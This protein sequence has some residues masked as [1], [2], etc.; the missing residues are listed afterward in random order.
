MSSTYPSSSKSVR[1]REKLCGSMELAALTLAVGQRTRQM[2]SQAV[3]GVF[4]NDARTC[5]CT[6]W[7]SATAA[8][9]CFALASFMACLP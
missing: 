8:A 3:L 6:R 1:S 7:I 5:A 9:R 4:S 2:Y